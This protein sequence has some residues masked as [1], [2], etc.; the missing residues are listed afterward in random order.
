MISSIS[1]G[2]CGHNTS[3]EKLANSAKLVRASGQCRLE[4]IMLLSTLDLL[5]S[6]GFNSVIASLAYWT[7]CFVVFILE[8]TSLETILMERGLAE[9]VHSRQS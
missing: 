3:S 6:N 1:N 2:C 8:C 5:S 9:E 7:L 4:Q